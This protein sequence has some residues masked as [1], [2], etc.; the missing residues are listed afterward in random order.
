MEFRRVKVFAVVLLVL[1]VAVGP[2]MAQDNNTTSD[3]SNSTTTTS[4][5][6]EGR[7]GDRR[8]NGSTD[9][10]DG[11]DDTGGGGY[12]RGV[13]ASGGS[14]GSSQGEEA[15]SDGYLEDSA[16][17]RSVGPN[18]S[19]DL[20]AGAGNNSSNASSDLS[21]DADGVKGTAINAALDV[22]MRILEFIT[23]QITSALTTVFQAIFSAVT[24][25]SA[26]NQGSNMYQ[27][28]GNGVWPG[29]YDSY[30]NLWQPLALALTALMTGAYVAFGRFG[31]GWMPTNVEQQGLFH[32][33]IAW[34][35]SSDLSWTLMGLYLDVIDKVNQVFV[36]SIEFESVVVGGASVAL[37]AMILIHLLNFWI[38]LV[39]LMIFGFR[40]V[41]IVGLTPIIPAVFAARA[42]PVKGISEIM[43]SL[44]RLWIYLVIL[45]LPVAAVMAVGFGPNSADMVSNAGLSGALIQTMLQVGTGVAAVFLPYAMYKKGKYS[46]LG[47]GVVNAIQNKRI[48]D[49]LDDQSD[50]VE[51]RRQDGQYGLPDH[52]RNMKI[53]ARNVGI[54]VQGGPGGSASSGGG[55]GGTTGGEGGNSTYTSSERRRDR[56][57][58]D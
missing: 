29:I 3:A 40:V 19:V 56:I 51:R 24:W 9:T 30:E 48:R 32:I 22:F 25:T 36:G 43:D 14:G 4:A 50:E 28:P 23:E 16:S 35:M 42:I 12:S 5:D 31:L 54:F 39:I 46:T 55:G 33:A 1:A 11:G 13:G 58:G 57:A 8:T 49:A 17:N 34:L 37:I 45:P 15:Y 47:F 21:S 18:G 41:G 20:G 2:V 53:K 6:D 26:P 7:L 10:T 38:V 52:V 27:N 44:W